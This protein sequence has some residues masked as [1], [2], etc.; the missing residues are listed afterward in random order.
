MPVAKMT[1]ITRICPPRGW[2]HAE[3]DASVPTGSCNGCT[4]VVDAA[5]TPAVSD[6]AERHFGRIRETLL[7]TSATPLAQQSPRDAWLE[8]DD[9][10]IVA[11]ARLD[12]SLV[13]ERNVVSAVDHVP[14]RTIQPRPGRP[15]RVM[16]HLMEPPPIRAT[17]A[18]PA[19]PR[20]QPDKSA[21]PL[22]PAAGGTRSH[23]PSS[24]ETP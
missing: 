11:L 22:R 16:R 4:I 19:D 8:H 3:R 10:R 2:S 24:T 5:Q 12:A 18:T 7:L 13:R 6:S 14:R 23:S 9:V 20:R 17:P 21:L 1:T 15:R